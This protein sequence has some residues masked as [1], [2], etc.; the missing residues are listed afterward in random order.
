MKISINRNT[1]WCDVFIESLSEL[2]VKYACISPG[3]R[4]T[5]LTIAKVKNIPDSG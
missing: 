5:P 4:S 1:L 2:G 3:S